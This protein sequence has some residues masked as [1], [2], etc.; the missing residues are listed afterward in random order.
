MKHRLVIGLVF[1]ALLTG[2]GEPAS[3]SRLPDKVKGNF[4]DD[5]RQRDINDE[6]IDCQ[7]LV[8]YIDTSSNHYRYTD[9]LKYMDIADYQFKQCRSQLE[10]R[11][12]EK[13][14]RDIDLT[15]ER[16]FESKIDRTGR[17]VFD[18]FERKICKV[19]IANRL[20]NYNQDY[21]MPSS[22]SNFLELSRINKLVNPTFITEISWDH[23]DVYAIYLS[24]T[25]SHYKL[26]FTDQ[27]KYEQA[28]KDFRT[29]L[30]QINPN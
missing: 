27:S 1:T 9:V 29:L 12:V 30:P 3:N 17:M 23:N 15:Q 6:P 22:D 24:T 4:F 26:F 16:F 14:A 21:I 19:E 10:A 20:E 25:S 7:V 2:C 8:D 11:R 13:C 28:L 5:M 18:R